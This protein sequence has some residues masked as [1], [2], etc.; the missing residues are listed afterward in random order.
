VQFFDIFFGQT[1]KMQV[2]VASINIPNA[3]PHIQEAKH[4]A[5]LQQLKHELHWS[6][7]EKDHFFIILRNRLHIIR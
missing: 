3:T 6:N 4:N 2:L 7:L 5:H 1:T